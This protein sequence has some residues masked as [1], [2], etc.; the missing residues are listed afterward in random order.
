VCQL[1]QSLYY[2]F[3]H[4]KTT[5]VERFRIVSVLADL[6]TNHEVMQT[7]VVERINLD[8]NRSDRFQPVLFDWRRTRE[9]MV[10]ET[11]GSC[12]GVRLTQ[13]LTMKSVFKDAGQENRPTEVSLLEQI[14]SWPG[15]NTDGLK[16]SVF[17][18]SSR[19]PNVS[20]LL[21]RYVCGLRPTSRV[22]SSAHPLLVC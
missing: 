4:V 7:Q 10:P 3:G 6:S 12:D 11:R 5:E 21:P 16:A 17:R 13:K 19:L 2:K 8:Q 20:A 15:P 9:D 1:G 14:F 18:T 22:F